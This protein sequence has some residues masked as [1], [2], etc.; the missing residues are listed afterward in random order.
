MKRIK[1]I[2]FIFFFCFFL[3]TVNLLQADENLQ[4]SQAFSVGALQQDFK[5]FREILEQEHCC[6]YEYTS[7][8]E[9][10]SLFDAHYALIDHEMTMNEFFQILAPITAKIGCMHTSTWMPGRFFITKPRNMFPLTVKLIDEQLAVIGT[11]NDSLEVPDGSILIEINK[12]PVDTIIADFRMITPADA[13]NPYFIDSQLSTRFS[14]FY[15]S[16]Y[17]L[18]DGFEITYIKPDSEDPVTAELTPTDDASVRKVVF[19]H[20]SNPPLEFEIMEGKNTAILTIYTFAYYSRVDYFRNFM[21]SCF[22][23]IKDKGIENLILDLRGNSGGDPFC[24]TILLSYLESEPV[25]YFAER[26]GKYADFADPIPLAENHFTGNLYTLIDG[27]CGSTNGHFCAL[28]D[29]NNI[30]TFV[31]TP[32]GAT[33]KCNAGKDTELRLPNTQMIITIGRTTYKAAVENMDKLA[34]I[35]P[36]I[37]VHETAEDIATG[38]DV[39]I[40][41]TLEEISNND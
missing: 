29:Y 26:Y 28:L 17:G 37:L 15:A 8:A 20:F 30:G 2:F 13:M 36:D 25:P 3:I 39:F 23:E 12:T 11:Y 22:K 7:K 40:E 41:A 4:S 5:R 1:Y 14:Q 19:R 24:S 38:R 35:M 6:T 16:M 21:D 31:G 27:R 10:D 18:P 33:F 34:P 9:M 32:S